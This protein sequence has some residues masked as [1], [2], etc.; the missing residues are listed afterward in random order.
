L[1][2]TDFTATT[3]LRAK[4]RWKKKN[5]DKVREMDRRHSIRRYALYG[6]GPSPYAVRGKHD[7]SDVKPYSGIGTDWMDYFYQM[8]NCEQKVQTMTMVD[9]EDTT[10]H[11]RR[12]KIYDRKRV[13]INNE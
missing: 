13:M 2:L 8:K 4:A 12:S 9:V 11:D 6:K 3:E 1:N 10:E 5:P 7:K